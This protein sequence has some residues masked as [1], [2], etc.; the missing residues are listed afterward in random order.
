MLIVGVVIAL[1]GRHV[2]MRSITKLA[3]AQFAD[4]AENAARHTTDVLSQANPLLDVMK[5]VVVDQGGVSDTTTFALELGIIFVGVPQLFRI[6][7]C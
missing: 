5:A 7:G 1:N 2:A 6:W 4:R 3:E